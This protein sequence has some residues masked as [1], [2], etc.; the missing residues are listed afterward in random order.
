MN[1]PFASRSAGTTPARHR[2]LWTT[3]RN[4]ARAHHTARVQRRRL[5]EELS[6]YNTPSA[7]NDLLVAVDDSEPG[8][9]EIRDILMVNLADY[10]RLRASRI[11][12]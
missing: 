8:S 1:A 11:A 12:S 5:R 7:I 2:G 3:V 6:A 4:E 10:H 9:A